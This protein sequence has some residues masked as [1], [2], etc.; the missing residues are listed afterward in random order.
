MDKIPEDFQ[1]VTVYLVVNNAT[2]FLKFVQDVFNA[3]LV[4]KH[5]RDENIIMHAEIKIGNSIIM[6]ADSTDEYA[7]MNAGIFIYVE[8]ADVTYKK[9]LNN[10]AS[11]VTQL[12][13]Q[14]YGRSGGVKDAFGNTWWITSVI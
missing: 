13:N 1:T 2:S 3:V 8:D 10:G 7:P 12:A 4:N 6:F 14:S 5:M 9:A 11:A